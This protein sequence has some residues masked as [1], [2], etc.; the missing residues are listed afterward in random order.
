MM[1]RIKTLVVV[2]LTMAIAPTVGFGQYQVPRPLVSPELAGRAGL[3]ILW[4]QD[5]PVDDFEKL[6]DLYLIE[7]N[8]YLLTNRN[9]MYVLQ[10]NTG[11]DLWNKSIGPV[12]SPILGFE[13][14]EDKL[15]TVVGSKFIELSVATGELMRAEQLK[16]GVTAA[17]SRNSNYVYLPGIDQRLHVLRADDLVKLFE[18]GIGDGGAINSVL[19]SEKYVLISTDA[20]TVVRMH[21]SESRRDW[22]FD[23]SD[24]IVGDIVQDVNS[25]YVTSRNSNLY[26]LD[27][28]TGKFMWKFSGAAL[29]QESPVKTEQMVYQY[30]QDKGLA[31]VNKKNG[32]PVWWLKE[33]RQFLC[34]SGGRSYVFTK[35]GK[36][37][38]M[39]NVAGELLYKVNFRNVSNC[40]SN[41]QN[42]RIYVADESG[43][44]CCLRPVE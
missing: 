13:K 15:V 22:R 18:V 39:D 19:A 8:L 10:S 33:G 24:T 37:A 1:R 42:S 12:G 23:A 14:F 25:V 32:E 43:R 26:K 29:L 4:W 17:V 30:C 40:V 16:V 34:E 20:G 7:G 36:L 28:L 44:L 27:L 38:V 31:A 9:Y 41:T 21:P 11:K 3:E 2:V 6:Q 5:L 35:N